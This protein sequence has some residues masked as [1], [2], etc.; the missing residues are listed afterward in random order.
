MS[1]EFGKKEVDKSI[2]HESTGFIRQFVF[3]DF[4][5][6]KTTDDKEFDN[7]DD[8]REQQNHLDRN[9]K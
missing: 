5:P 4:G 3:D 8:A 2:E 9:R 1:D 7:K 6:Y